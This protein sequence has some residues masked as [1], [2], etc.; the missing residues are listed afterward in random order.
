MPGTLCSPQ[1]ILLPHVLQGWSETCSFDSA[2]W[3][4]CCLLHGHYVDIRIVSNRFE[5]FGLKVPGNVDISFLKHHPL[6]R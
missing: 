5:I 2:P 4:K 6:L 3:S 1:G